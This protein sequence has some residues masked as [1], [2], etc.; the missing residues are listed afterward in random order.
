MERAFLRKSANEGI[1]SGFNVLLRIFALSMASDACL[2]L[3]SIS[4][5]SYYVNSS[6]SSAGKRKFEEY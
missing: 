4:T 1:W 5:N 2:A 6:D 3:F